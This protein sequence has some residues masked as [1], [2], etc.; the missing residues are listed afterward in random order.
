MTDLENVWYF[1]W[2]TEEKKIATLLLKCPANGLQFI[3]EVLS[4]NSG[5][6]DQDDAGTF[7]IKSR[8]VQEEWAAKRRSLASLISL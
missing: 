4:E 8:F 2:F 7:L 6:S 1:L 5:S 3:R